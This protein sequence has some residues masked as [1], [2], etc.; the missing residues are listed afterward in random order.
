LYY[1]LIEFGISVKLVS[2]IKVSLNETYSK[3]RIDRQLP[4]TYPIQNDLKQGHAFPPLHFNAGL[5]S[6]KKLGGVGT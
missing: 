5:G 3:F 6:S 1:I 4:E 2:V